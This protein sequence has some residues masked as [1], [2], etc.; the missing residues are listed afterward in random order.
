M[1]SKKVAFFDSGI[2]G[3]T[4]L[5]KCMENA[6]DLT[7]YY[8]GDNARA[9]YGNLP[10]ETIR[11][12]VFEAFDLFERLDVTAAVVAC[13]T[14]TAVCMDDLRAR[15]TFPIIGTEPAIF[16]AASKGGE[17][18][19]LATRA[20]VESKRMLRLLERASLLYPDTRFRLAPCDDL[21]GGIE[22]GVPFERLKNFLPTC[23]P[24][25]VVLGCT[26]YVYVRKE[27]ENY[28]SVPV[29]D[30][31]EG[32]A[33]RLKEVLN[34]TKNRCFSKNFTKNRDERPPTAEICPKQVFE[35]EFCRAEKEPFLNGGYTNKCL[36]KCTK[37]GEKASK[38][39]DFSQIFFFGSGREINYKKYEQMFVVDKNVK[40]QKVGGKV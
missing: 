39:G 8:Y 25:A 18:L 20:T 33:K 19:V 21:A 23:V 3:L 26:H 16:P 31:N 6:D 15:Y 22:K 11:R 35:A 1:T 27:I 30:G 5:S 36:Q 14:A 32:V 38:S 4:V 2:G 17:V 37:N 9:P 12:Y 10:P 13:N 34:S 7:F 28:Y 40:W 24:D 29:F